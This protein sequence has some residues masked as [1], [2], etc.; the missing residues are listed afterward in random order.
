MTRPRIFIVEDEALSRAGVRHY[1]AEGFDIIGEADNVADSVEMIR[2][3]T[4]DLVL[5]DLRLKGG[6]GVEVI[7]QVRRTHTGIKFLALTVSTSRFD[8]LQLLSIGVDGYL[9]KGVIGDDLADRVNEALSGARPISKQVAGFALDIHE[10]IAE[11]ADVDPLTPRQLEV[12]R[13]IAR[14][15]TYRETAA[16]LDI[17]VKTLEKHMGSIFEKLGLASRHEL[18]ALAYESGLIDTDE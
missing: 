11:E 10:N 15:Y 1:L 6:T 16:K 14:G 17:S 7:E 4:P 9:T 2:H 8:V 13:H 18:S 5:L 3:L 12:T